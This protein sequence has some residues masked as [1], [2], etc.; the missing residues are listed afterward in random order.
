MNENNKVQKLKICP[1]C[2]FLKG[3]E[4]LSIKVNS[5]LK[6]TD[7]ITPKIEPSIRDLINLKNIKTPS[8]YNLNKH[9]NDCLKDFIVEDVIK[10]KEFQKISE[11]NIDMNEFDN[12]SLVQKDA[13]YQKIL[14]QI[15]YNQLLITKEKTTKDN[16][17]T[18]KI[19]NDLINDNNINV[20][21]II[22][23]ETIDDKLNIEKIGFEIIQIICSKGLIKQKTGMDIA[24]LFI[25]NSDDIECFNKERINK[26][27]SREEM[28]DL[29]DKMQDSIE[30]LEY[31]KLKE[32]GKI[33][34]KE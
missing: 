16:V 18:L 28:K 3:D 24:E 30:F 34:I 11:I 23:I 31:M 27:M 14:H 8:A 1:I 10:E 4:N 22:N 2:V 13:M 17:G 25:K 12:N 32:A 5:L 6:T 15:Y 26:P 21:D 33:I 20:N 29:I 7:K 9:K 19:L